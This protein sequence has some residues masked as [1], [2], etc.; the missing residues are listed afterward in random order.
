[1]PDCIGDEKM[2]KKSL[3]E[4]K[5]IIKMADEK[6]QLSAK[7]FK[8]GNPTQEGLNF[9]YHIA[10][11]FGQRLWFYGKSTSYKNKPDINV[12]KCT[13]CGLCVK[14]CPMHNLEKTDGRI[15]SKKKCTMC[16]RCLNHCPAK[17][18]T[19]LGKEI[20]EQ[21]YVEKYL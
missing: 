11:L 12:Q 14:N 17:A 15:V 5:K 8:E 21:C 10:G 20:H 19:I 2:L 16:Y 18:L 9:L 1:M 13:V 3:E 6:I 7:Q 4:N